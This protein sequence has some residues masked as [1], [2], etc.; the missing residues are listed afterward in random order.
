M[1]YSDYLSRFRLVH[2]LI[3]EETTELR[4]LEGVMAWMAGRGIPLAAA[5]IVAQDE[6]SLDFVV[7]LQP[8]M[9]YVVFGIT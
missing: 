3:A 1:D 2:P 6:F 8:D 4:G 9:L 7:P 5:E